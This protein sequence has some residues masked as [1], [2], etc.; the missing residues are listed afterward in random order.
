MMCQALFQELGIH[1]G[2][3]W[4]TPLLC[5]VYIPEGETMIKKGEVFTVL[6]VLV[7]SGCHNKIPQMGRLK[8]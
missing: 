4:T 1:H 2:T 8:Q 5:G 7:S 3:R 6:G